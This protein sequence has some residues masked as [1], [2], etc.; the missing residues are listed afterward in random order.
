MATLAKERQNVYNSK[1]NEDVNKHAYDSLKFGKI[2]DKHKWKY[3]CQ[4][5][6]S[7][8][9]TKKKPYSSDFTDEMI[10]EML[11]R[12]CYYCQ[13]I[14]TTIDRVDSRMGHIP[15][16]CVG[17]C[18]PCNKSKGNGDRDSFLRKAF[19]RSCGEYFDDDVNIWSDNVRRPNYTEH[20]KKANHQGVIFELSRDEWNMLTI[21][22]CAYCHRDISLNKWNG[23]DRI[24]PSNGYTLE[25]TISCCDDC[26]VDKGMCLIESMR[27]RNK[28]IAERMKSEDILINGCDKVLRNKGIKPNYKRVCVRG[29][30]YSNMMNASVVLGNGPTYV[31]CCVQSGR[32]P[33][34]IFIVTDEFYKEYKNNDLYITKNM[35]I[36]FEHYLINSL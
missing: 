22:S 33:D 21:G 7:S 2:I 8:A 6:R 5:I 15:K 17:C 36:G 19:Y 32:Y 3:Y 24:V 18:L 20:V 30:L 16:N 14:A 27:T 13:D 35:F 11:V 23:V 10:F 12:R 34:D 1:R 31:H 9:E 26:N 28:K 4:R 29:K 25:N